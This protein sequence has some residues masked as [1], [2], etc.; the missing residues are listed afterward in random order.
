VEDLAVGD[1]A[2]GC[3]A[4]VGVERD[5]GGVSGL[6]AEVDVEDAEEAAQEEAGSDEENAGEG[7]LGDD[8][9][10]AEAG[11]GVASGGAGG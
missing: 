2:P 8:E 4:V 7:D 11:G 1:G 5:G 10:A 3:V 9:G 6:E